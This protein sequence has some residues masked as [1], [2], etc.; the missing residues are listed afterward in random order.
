MRLAKFL[1]LAGI[2]SRR[3]ASRMIDEQLV[4][5]DGQVAG[6][7]SFV[8]GDEEIVANGLRAVR[9]EEYRYILY[10][11][12]VGIDCNCDLNNSQSIVNQ[13][14]LPSRLFPVGR[15]DKDSHGLM[16]LTNDGDLCH[17]LLSPDFSHSKT[18]LVTVKPHHLQPDIDNEFQC[19]M[20]EGIELDGV[21][22]RPCELTIRSQNRF[23]ITL[24]QGLNRQIRRMSRALGYRVVDLQRVSIV[25]LQLDGLALNRW[26]DLR[27][28]E[29][30]E[31]RAQIGRA[32]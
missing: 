32:S 27:L 8:T 22:T 19:R 25:N 31:L 18:Y 26:R 15:I 17:R 6:H 2:C 11:K 29:L 7:L 10:H 24:T 28:D 14:S 21:L 13:I 1:S 20:V 30:T 9:P 3:A 23:S 4:T 16:L 12:P 5:V